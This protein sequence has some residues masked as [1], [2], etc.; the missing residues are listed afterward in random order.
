MLPSL[1]TP[2]PECDVTAA[3]QLARVNFEINKAAPSPGTSITLSGVTLVDEHA[4]PIAFGTRETVWYDTQADLACNTAVPAPNTDIV[5]AGRS[6]QTGTTTT[7]KDDPAIKFFDS[8]GPGGPPNGKWDAPGAGGPTDDSVVYDADGNGVYDAGEAVLEGPALTAGAALLDDLRVKY[9]DADSNSVRTFGGPLSSGGTVTEIIDNNPPIASFTFS[10]A[11]PVPPGPAGSGTTVTFDV[12]SSSDSDGTIASF[13]MDFGDGLGEQDVTLLAPLI[14][15]TLPC[16]QGTPP[17]CD[18]PVTLRVV[19]SL[20]A[21]GAARDNVGTPLVDSQP[22]H[23]TQTVHIEAAAV[24]QPPVAANDAYSTAEDTVLTVAAPGVL[25]NDSDP[26]LD[27]IT[28]VLVT[29]PTHGTLTLSSNGGFTYTPALNFNGADSFTYKANDGLLL[30][31]TATVTLTVTAVNDAPVAL[32]DSYTTAEDTVLTVAAPGV[33]SNDSDVESS[34]LTAVLVTGPTHGTLTLAANGGFTYTPALNFFGSD[35]FTY[36]AS[37]GSLLSATATV[38]ITVTAVNDAPAAV[39]DSYTTAEDTVLTVAA[40]GVLSNDNDVDSLTLTAVLVTGPSSGTLT[41]NA[42]GSFTYTPDLNFFG[43]DS[44]TYKASDGLLLSN[45]ATVT[46]TVTAVNDAPVAANDSYTTAQ[47]TVLTV[48]APGVLSNDSD[49]DSATLTAV[50][51][52]GPAHGTLTLN[53]NGGFTYT[54]AAGFTGTDGFTYQASDGLLLSNTAAVTIAVGGPNRAPVAANDTYTTAEDTVLTVTAPGVL[55]N[56]NDP[57]GDPITAV[58]VTGP[59]SGTLTLNSNGG[60]T[61]TP[62]LNFF[63]SDSFT[64]Q[65]SDGLLL[66]STAT[67][68]ITVTAVNDAPVAVNNSYTVDQDAVLNVAAPGVLFNDSDVDSLSLTAVLVTGPIHGTLTLNTDGSFMYT[69]SPG[70]FGTDSFT[71]KANDGS[72][73][74]NIAT[75]TIT[76]IPVHELVAQNDSY[77]TAEDTVL[78]VAAPGVLANDT[79]SQGHILTAVLVS[80]PSSGTLTLNADGS[81]MYAPN[82][83]FFGTDSFTYQAND[84]SISSN[85][86]TVSI[87]VTA[88]NDTPVASFT[89]SPASPTAGQT[90][91][92]DGTAS[93]D[94]DGVVVTWA[95]DFGDTATGSGSTTTH[96]YSV[97]ATYTVT[98]TVTDDAGATGTASSSI[99][100]TPPLEH[101]KLARWKASPANHHQVLSKDPSNVFRAFGANDGTVTVTAYVQFHI[102]GD[103]GVNTNVY[104]QVVTLAPTAM[105]NGKLDPRFATSFTPSPGS[106]TVTATIYYSAALSMTIGDPSFT[107]DLASQKTFSFTTVP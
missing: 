49:V 44:F 20:G 1:A 46:L 93:S 23:T 8:G 99:T 82:L 97:A 73:D 3:V 39:S 50:L 15:Y 105:I 24:N 9:V 76:V 68:T 28:A 47:D 51:V 84:G 85:T 92:F 7:C 40:P 6:A 87:T 79:D 91:T 16:D 61:Y 52:T 64:Y 41:L 98:L 29:G 65:A 75:V 54:P 32:A 100:V 4:V 14:S 60:F 10:P 107:P 95:W 31:G 103:G 58:L 25:S 86:A 71:Y 70:F 37:D 81:F 66:S 101:A 94:V 35:S 36:Q 88:V 38:T 69:P 89:F 80:G 48:A 53:A 43:T 59:T 21:T 33:L 74:S 2:H 19:D 18:I 22:S 34:P 63:G 67:V 5:I 102:M 83:N 62:A 12:S 26:N 11:N 104:T 17:P 42:D 27:P 30:S 72:L 90:V 57:D 56:D 55:A 78:T 96:V 106:Y 77:T 45:T 13:F